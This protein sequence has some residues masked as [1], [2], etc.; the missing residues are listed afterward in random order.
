MVVD[1][2]LR[3]I[4][5]GSGK[6]GRLATRGYVPV[7][8][9]GDAE[10]TARTLVEI[11]GH[12]WVLPGDTATIDADGTVELLGRGSLCI[13]TG[14]EKVYPEEVEAV[15]VAIAVA[16]Q[17]GVGTGLQGA[18]HTDASGAVDLVLG[19]LLSTVSIGEVIHRATHGPKAPSTDER[20]TGGPLRAGAG[21][22][23]PDGRERQHARAL[24]GRD[25]ERL[26][27]TPRSTPARHRA[28]DQVAHSS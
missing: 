2:N 18:R 23:E 6:A 10:R 11:D 19:V 17:L 26:L 13:N 16:I 9:Y 24:P 4:A 27:T 25:L 12:R 28:V 22:R 3:P 5:P 7:G 8:Y 1:D 15:L 14:G 21:R 20:S